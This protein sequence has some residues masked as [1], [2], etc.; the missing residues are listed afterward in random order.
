VGAGTGE[1]VGDAI[2]A[3]HRQLEGAFDE[4]RRALGEASDLESTRDAFAALREQIEIHFDQEDRL[5]YNTIA[6]LRPD[7]KP[8]LDAFTR[9]HEGFRQEL[10]ALASHL[11]QGRLEEARPVFASLDRSFREHERAEERVLDR[12]DR[13]RPEP[14]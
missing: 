10:A 3:D 14:R 11:D 1:A 6:G 8:E 4:V 12:I 9:G 13:A 5:Y 7:L 2:R